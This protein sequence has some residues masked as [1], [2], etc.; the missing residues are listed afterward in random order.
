M[1]SNLVI[2]RI[3]YGPLKIVYRL[4]YQGYSMGKGDFF[5]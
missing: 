1:I 5:A 4:A 2:M 3:F